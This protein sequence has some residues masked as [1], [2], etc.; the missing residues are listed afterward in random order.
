MNKQFQIPPA[1][2][3]PLLSGMLSS[4]PRTL[5][6]LFLSAGLLAWISRPKATFL[7]I[8]LTR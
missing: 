8:T 3:L 4:Q 2:D 7:S 6:A 5:A 1:E